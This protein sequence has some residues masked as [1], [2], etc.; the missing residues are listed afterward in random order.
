MSIEN[1]IIEAL[2]WR[3]AVKKFDPTKKIKQEHWKILEESLLL[4]PSSYG[5]QP[6]KFLVVQN[7]ALRKQLTPA[8]WNQT[9]VED[10]SHYVVLATLKT[11]TEDYIGS[12]IQST[13]E[14]RHMDVASLMGYQKMIIGDL[15]QGPRSKVIEHWAQKQSYIAMGNIMHSAALL[16]IDSCPME[17]IDPKAYDKILGLENTPYAS[18]AAVALGYRS[19]EDKYQLAKKV[20]FPKDQIIKVLM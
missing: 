3:Y 9:Q 2:E 1:Q 13:A 19:S 17:G 4:S 8:S 15:V 7:V 20:R 16:K 12:F 10:C 14:T 5:L 18:A 6:W 11:I